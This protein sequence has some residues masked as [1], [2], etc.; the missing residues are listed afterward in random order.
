MRAAIQ[1]GRARPAAAATH[2]DAA[3]ATD[4]AAE[5]GV[6]RVPGRTES[7]DCARCR[8]ISSVHDAGDIA[9]SSFD[10]GA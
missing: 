5:A 6:C 10:A 7:D 8:N 2:S 3:A 1:R 9:A 4:A